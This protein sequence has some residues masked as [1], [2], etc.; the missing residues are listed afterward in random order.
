MGPL[1]VTSVGVLITLQDVM[2]LCIQLSIFALRHDML[3]VPGTG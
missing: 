3:P 2:A 1:P